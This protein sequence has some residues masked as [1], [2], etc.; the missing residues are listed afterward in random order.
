MKELLAKIERQLARL[1]KIQSEM[2]R[3]AEQMPLQEAQSEPSP[4][5]LTP[6]EMR[7]FREVVQGWTN[8]QISD[9]LYV[10]PRTVQTHLSSILNKLNLEN[11]SQLVR[12]AYE[13]GY[14]KPMDLS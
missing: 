11:R 14:E 5:P 12:F 8:K 6:A 7:V 2:Q 4:L 1:E 10:S 9:H 3:L 13:N